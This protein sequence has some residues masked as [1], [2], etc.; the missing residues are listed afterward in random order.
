MNTRVIEEN[1]LTYAIVGSEGRL[2][3]RTLKVTITEYRTG[4]WPVR[5]TF[6]EGRIEDVDT[7]VEVFRERFEGYLITKCVTQS[8]RRAIR[9]T[10]QIDLDSEL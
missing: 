8:C 9:A 7:G 5:R 4:R 3:Q 1:S 10:E 2:T 6:Y